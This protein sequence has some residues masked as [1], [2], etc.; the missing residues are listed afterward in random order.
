[1]LKS[2]FPFNNYWIYLTIVL[3][4][5]ANACIEPY[6]ADINGDVE[7]ISIEGSIIKGN[8]AQHVSISTTTSLLEKEFKPIRGCEV[9]VVDDLNN[10]FLFEENTIGKYESVIAD[11]NLVYNRQYKLMITT[12]KGDKYE[13]LFETLNISNKIDTLYYDIEKKIETYS[14][15]E[16]EGL[17]FYID[18]KAP[19][20]ISRYFRWNLTETYEYTTTGYISMIVRIGPDTIETY[21]PADRWEVYRCWM[22]NEVQGIYLSNTTNITVN[23]KKKIPL[24][25]V[26]TMGDRLKIKYSLLVNQYSLSEGAYKYW[27][28]NKIAIEDSDGLYTTQ[29]GQAFTNLHSVNNTEEKVLGYFWASSMTESRIIIPRINSLVVTEEICYIAEYDPRLHK[30]LP[31]YFRIEESGLLVTGHP[32]CFD[33]TLRGGTIT[34]PDFFY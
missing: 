6:E 26:S 14:G 9:K 2:H 24:N 18:I 32:N 1:M 11:N 7:L 17:Q 15:E 30:S 31:R 5:V 33:C 23:E 13:S 29:P 19:D 3:S 22:S 20:S 28:Q 16:L 4:I 25:Y 8:P 12:P 27:Q 34:K 21:V 10:E